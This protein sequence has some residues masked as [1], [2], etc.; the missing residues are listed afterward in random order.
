MEREKSLKQKKIASQVFQ[1]VRLKLVEVDGS[2][3]MMLLS[4]RIL[5][6][7]KI[8]T[9]MRLRAYKAW[10]EESVPHCHIFILRST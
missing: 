8:A 3:L 2:L 7:M 4:F 6:K 5:L 10:D 9:Q 1:I